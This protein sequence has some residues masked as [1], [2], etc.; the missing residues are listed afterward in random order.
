MISNACA[1]YHNRLRSWLEK[2]DHTQKI[3]TAI[4][5]AGAVVAIFGKDTDLLRWALAASSVMAIVNKVL[6]FKR[7]ARDHLERCA[8]F[9]DFAAKLAGVS[10]V[11]T[12]KQIAL[13][14]AERIRIDKNAPPTVSVL[15]VICMNEE[16][17]VRSHDRE[18][19]RRIH[20][21]Q[22]IWPF[23]YFVTIGPDNFPTFHE[24]KK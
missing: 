18:Y 24:L 8:K 23:Y 11:P 22:R 7:R 14:N 9:N 10:N 6:D 16:A 20:K 17:D 1:R 12:A 21:Y 4:V 2:L 13:W 5:T 3:F 15:D 19:R